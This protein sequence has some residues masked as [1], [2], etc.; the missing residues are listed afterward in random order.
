[1]SRIFHTADWHLG[2]RL[3][4]HERFDEHAQFLAW[5]LEQIRQ[6]QPNLLIIAGDIFD[7]AN[8]SQQSLSQYYGFLAGVSRTTTEVLVLGGNHDS[9]MAL[10]APRDLLRSLRIRV[11]GSAP[12]DH[13]EAMLDLGDIVVCA[14]PFLRERDVRRASAGQSFDEVASQIS[15][16]ISKHYRSILEKA[17]E[18]AQGRPTVAT[19]HLTA[20][21]IQNSASERAI[22]IGNLGAVPVDCFSGFAYTALGHIHRP[23]LVGGFDHIRYSGSPLALGFDETDT[24]KQL[25]LVTIGARNNVEVEPIPIPRFRRMLRLSCPLDHLD[26]TL[27]GIVLDRNEL[28]PWTELT[29]E[30]GANHPDLDLKVKNALGDSPIRILKLVVPR[31]LNGD[32]VVGAAFQGRMLNEIKPE[33]VFVERLRREAIEPESEE[34]K[35]LI[36]T[37]AELLSSMQ[38]EATDALPEEPKA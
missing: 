30:D 34:A 27:R 25:L 19:G 8:P 7:S 9:A 1:M 21:G 5:L 11:V 14:V 10:N 35:L 24:A 4:E 28:T 2:A 17:R 38:E 20:M 18:L 16:G 6:R 32:D 31:A 26:E 36:G 15:D 22:H 3:I 13:G 23:Q 12:L 33:E 29:V 37:F